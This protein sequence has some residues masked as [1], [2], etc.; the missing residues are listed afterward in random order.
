MPDSRVALDAY[1]KAAEDGDEKA[2][3]AMMTDRAAQ[4][5]SDEELRGLLARDHKEFR[6]RRKGFSDS[7]ERGGRAQIFFDDGSVA[8]FLIEK[9][10][11]RVESAGLVAPRPRTPEDAV[12]SLKAALAARDFERLL[13][14]LTKD[15]ADALAGSLAR[16][17]K[18]LQDLDTAIVEVREDR[19][20]IEFADGRVLTLRREDRVWRV[21][22]IE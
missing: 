13:S 12:R 20:R 19:A 8:S 10:Q 5:L 3:R 1:L 17:D 2:L 11:F 6:A 15:S 21:E 22:E 16:L 18:S 14:A 7:P 4:E 9:G